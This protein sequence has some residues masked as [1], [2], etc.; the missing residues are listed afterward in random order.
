MG[1]AHAASDLRIPSLVVAEA[2]ATAAI[3]FWLHNKEAIGLLDDIKAIKLHEGQPL[4][5]TIESL[6]DFEEHAFE[7]FE[8]DLVALAD[9]AETEARY[10]F[11]RGFY[12]LALPIIERAALLRFR[13]VGKAAIQTLRTQLLKAK[14][15]SRL[16]H[17]DEALLIA[18]A[19][20][21]AY[22]ANPVFGPQHPDTLAS[23]YLVA[24]LLSELGRIDEALPNR[25]RRRRR[26]QG[27]PGA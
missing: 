8:P 22:E 9:A 17:A 13:T 5:P 24:Q 27:K 7:M 19:V 21:N 14:I 11:E 3:S 20:A 26:Q 18:R 16:G 12:H 6:S 25:P 15:L 23:R 1:A 10:R 4:L 2:Y